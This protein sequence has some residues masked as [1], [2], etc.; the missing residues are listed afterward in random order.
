MEKNCSLR[1]LYSCL[2]KL[3]KAFLIKP[4]YR[5]NIPG[6]AALKSNTKYFAI[7]QRHAACERKFRVL[8]RGPV[9]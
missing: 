2:D 5:Y 7:K 6:K 3:E 1:T 4:I 8:W 9:S